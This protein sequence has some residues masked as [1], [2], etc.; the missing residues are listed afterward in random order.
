MGESS[1][2]LGQREVVVEPPPNSVLRQAAVATV[3]AVTASFWT[4]KVLTTGMGETG[5]DFLYHDQLG[6]TIA[7]V[8]GGVGLVAALVL[9]F[10]ARQYVPWM[11]A[12]QARS[13]LERGRQLRNHR[14]L[15]G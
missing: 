11:A 7:L 6:P 13:A 14:S 1:N 8:V 3:P 12:N 9:Q 15:L 10:R 5:A 2:K 4:T